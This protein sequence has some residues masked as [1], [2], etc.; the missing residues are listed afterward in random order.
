MT[1]GEEKNT[2]EL[3][4]DW[5]NNFYK[6]I[7][8][9]DKYKNNIK[10]LEQFLEENEWEKRINK[11]KGAFFSFVQYWCDYVESIAVNSKNLTWKH[12]PGYNR[13][14]HAFL[15]EMKNTDLVDFTD[16]FNKALT[17]LLNNEK[18]LNTFVVILYKKANT[19]DSS[20]ILKM[21]N[22]LELFFSA[23]NKKNRLIPPTFD[24]TYFFKGFKMVL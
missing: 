20:S 24:Y 16:R 4:F 13:I 3:L 10:E 18:L 14:L 5:E 22:Y 8:T 19:N 2:Y 1:A 17:S 15:V 23:I 9:E 11:R 7:E 12:F 6:F 21:L